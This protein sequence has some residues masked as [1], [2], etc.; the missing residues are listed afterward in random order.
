ML[1]APPGLSTAFTA[2]DWLQRRSVQFQWYNRDFNHFDDFLS[3]FSSRKR[4]NVKKE[5]RKLHA[6]G[7]RIERIDGDALNESHIQFFYQCYRATYQKRS[8]HDGY[9]LAFLLACCR[10]AP[11]NCW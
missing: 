7:Y 6:P 8:G 9:L 10:F 3:L 4:K 5:R 11:S 1:F 2:Q